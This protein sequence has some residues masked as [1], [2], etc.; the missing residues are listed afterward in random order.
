MVPVNSKWAQTLTVD[1]TGDGFIRVVSEGDDE[2]GEAGSST[3]AIQ[4]IDRGDAEKLLNY[5]FATHASHFPIVSKADFLSSEIKPL[6]F[7]ALCGASI[8]PPCPH[9]QL[10]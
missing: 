4:G 7:N 2:P 9:S 6:L 1:E 10:N 3:T 8:P 5:Y